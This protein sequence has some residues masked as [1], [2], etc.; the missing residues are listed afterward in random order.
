MAGSTR[1]DGTRVRTVCSYCGVGC[2]IVLEIG[3][4]PD[5]RITPI[6]VVEALAARTTAS[7]R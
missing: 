1:T 5:G 6:I 3:T 7:G 4:G 2:G